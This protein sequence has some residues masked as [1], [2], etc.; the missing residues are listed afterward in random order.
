MQTDK[1]F[2]SNV[3]DSSIGNFKLSGIA[4]IEK[5]KAVYVTVKANGD[6]TINSTAPTDA[7][8]VTGSEINK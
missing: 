4:D 2:K 5:G 8:E 1:G 3:K 7:T 6:V